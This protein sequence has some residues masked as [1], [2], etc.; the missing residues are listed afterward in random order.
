VANGGEVDA[1]G[2]NSNKN[3]QVLFPGGI[4]GFSLDFKQRSEG[5]T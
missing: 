3:E 4:V 2:A 1:N 5:C